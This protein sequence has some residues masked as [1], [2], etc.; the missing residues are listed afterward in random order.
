MYKVVLF[1][2]TCKTFFFFEPKS[3][4]FGN[5]LVGPCRNNLLNSENRKKE[6]QKFSQ[7]YTLYIPF[8]VC[9]YPVKKSIKMSPLL[10]HLINI[11][12]PLLKNT[13][14]HIY[15]TP[16]LRKRTKIFPQKTKIH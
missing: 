6:Q 16:F 3:N 10:K 1:L 7:P 2:Q 9:H 11:E 15:Y 13:M 5:Q 14:Q 12:H 8:T 4:Y